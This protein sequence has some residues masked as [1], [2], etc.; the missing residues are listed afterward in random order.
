MTVKGKFIQDLINALNEENE[1]EVDYLGNKPPI[2]DVSFLVSVVDQQIENY[3]EFMDDITK[4]KYHIDSYE[5]DHS[6]GYTNGKIRI[7]IE[8]SE[9]EKESQY[10]IDAYYDYCYYIEF[11]F[12]QRHW[13]YCQCTPEDEGYN[14]K[15][16]CCGCGCDWDAPAFRLIREYVLGCS[17]WDGEERDYWNYKEQFEVNEQNKNEEVENFK[18]EQ[19]KLEL[20]AEI[21]RLQV[22]LNEL[23]I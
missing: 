3:K 21:A 1:Y 12:D 11:L 14:P 7:L 16:D 13:G 23:D 2:E 8:K 9:E 15:Y 5:E 17:S 10:L 4:H 22:K 6:E 18:K 19:K 20:E